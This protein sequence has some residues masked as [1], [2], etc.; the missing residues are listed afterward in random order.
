MS[1][2]R[3]RYTVPLRLR[4][5]LRRSLVEAE[6]REEL[7]GHFDRLVEEHRR[8]R[9]R[10]WTEKGATLPTSPSALLDS[11]EEAW[12]TTPQSSVDRL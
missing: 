4:S 5:I 7:Q 10:W 1:F 2:G 8:S 6:L 11:L 9:S 12:N 3:W